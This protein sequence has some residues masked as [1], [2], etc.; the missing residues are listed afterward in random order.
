MTLDLQ[1][2]FSCCIE[3]K[4]LV[5]SLNRISAVLSNAYFL[6]E[7][8]N[9]SNMGQCCSGTVSV[10]HRNVIWLEPKPNALWSAVYYQALSGLAFVIS[11][12]SKQIMHAGEHQFWEG[13]RKVGCFNPDMLSQGQCLGFEQHGYIHHVATFLLF[14]GTELCQDWIMQWPFWRFNGMEENIPLGFSTLPATSLQAEVPF[15]SAVLRDLLIK[16][17]LRPR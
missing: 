1:A 5:S 16:D 2:D 6:L 4:G 8:Q 15:S 13:N 11:T 9:R 14:Q 12:Q 3:S 10:C 7:E 17:N